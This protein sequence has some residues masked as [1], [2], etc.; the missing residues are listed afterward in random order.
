MPLA[1][2]LV[3]PES[4]RRLLVEVRVASLEHVERALRFQRLRLHVLTK[5]LPGVAIALVLVRP[6]LFAL[7]GLAAGFAGALHAWRRLAEYHAVVVDRL[8]AVGRELNRVGPA[9]TPEHLCCLQVRVDL[10]LAAPAPGWCRLVARRVA[11][12]V[13]AACRPPD[14]GRGANR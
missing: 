4:S 9:L 5:V 8:G 7:V 6:G 2:P 1:E 14:G 3:L 13:S 10:L 11:R 12:A